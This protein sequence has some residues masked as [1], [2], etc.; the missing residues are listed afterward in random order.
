[1][2]ADSKRRRLSFGDY[3]TYNHE[4]DFEDEKKR[5]CTTLRQEMLRL[6]EVDE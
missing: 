4:N 5:I 1:M 3:I 6:A 2:Y